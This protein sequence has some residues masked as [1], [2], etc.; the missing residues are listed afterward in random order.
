MAR[1]RLPEDMAQPGERMLAWAASHGGNV[2]AS[3]RAL[4]LPTGGD[5]STSNMSRLAWTSIDRAVWE[6]PD[7]VVFARGDGSAR[8]WRVTL[9]QPGRIPEVVRERVTASI[10]VSEYVEL[11]EGAG[12]RI[13]GRRSDGDDVIDWNVT[14]DPGLDP[15]DPDLRSAALAALADL[16]DS[17]GI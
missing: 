3:N 13:V 15:D 17:L 12:V 1:I 5:V 7:L 2:I 14:F 9:T 8:Q 10:V 11:A 16:R 6:D 4:Y